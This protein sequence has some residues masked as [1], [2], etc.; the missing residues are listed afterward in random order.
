MSVPRRRF[1]ID[2]N[3]L[4]SA[5]L[6]PAGHSRQAFDKA[7]R[8]GFVL[9]SEET[10]AELE[11]VIYRER[12]DDYIT[13]EERAYFLADLLAKTVF[14]V[15][16]ERVAACSDPDD[17]RFLELALGGDAAFVVTGNLDDFPPSPW[18]GIRILPPASFLNADVS[19]L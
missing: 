7:N 3:V 11:D 5:L 8:S 19:V 10:F 12:F 18:R 1:V 2:T 13:D 4:V 9:Q 15:P 16:S 6:T 14:V 17:D